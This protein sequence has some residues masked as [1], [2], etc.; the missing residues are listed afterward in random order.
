[1]K[2]SVFKKKIS[3]HGLLYLNVQASTLYINRPILE[4]LKSYITMLFGKKINKLLEIH[5]EL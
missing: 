1:M 3:K 5:Y 2:L 4:R